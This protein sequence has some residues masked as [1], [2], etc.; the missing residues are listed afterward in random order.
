MNNL[1]RTNGLFQPIIVEQKNDLVSLSQKNGQFIVVI[2][3]QEI[4]L[5]KNNERIQ[6]GK[7]QDTYV[8][9]V[10]PNSPS[11]GQ[12]WFVTEETQESPSEG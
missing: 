5:D 7:S 12:L 8:S 9:S 4:F 3:T 6:I 2:D 1:I 10:E 11:E